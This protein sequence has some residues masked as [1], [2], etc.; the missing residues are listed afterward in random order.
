MQLAISIPLL[1]AQLST[2]SD[3]SAELLRNECLYQPWV[4]FGGLEWL[5]STYVVGAVSCDCYCNYCTEMLPPGQYPSTMGQ[6]RP[7]MGHQGP[8]PPYGYPQPQQ[9]IGTPP[10]T[11]SS[12]SLAQSSPHY[13]VASNHPSQNG[14]SLE[15]LEKVSSCDISFTRSLICYLFLFCLII[16]CPS[17]AM[18]NVTLSTNTY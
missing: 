1:A 18:E 9:S 12:Y 4:N 6:M 5:Y 14:S 13:P 15:Q 8:S 17:L 10:V 11:Q 3:A 7:A 16:Y 2:I